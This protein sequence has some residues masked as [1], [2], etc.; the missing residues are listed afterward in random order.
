MQ[1]L[2]DVGDQIWVSETFVTACTHAGDLMGGSSSSISSSMV[3]NGFNTTMDNNA[4][5]SYLIGMCSRVHTRD[6]R[7][8]QGGN[9]NIS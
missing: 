5:G 3:S 4:S 2:N 7:T 6:T 1:S 8:L 9:D